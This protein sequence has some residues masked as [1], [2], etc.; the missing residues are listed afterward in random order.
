LFSCSVILVNYFTKLSFLFS[1]P[2]YILPYPSFCYL[3][4]AV[5]SALGGLVGYRIDLRRDNA[6]LFHQFKKAPLRWLFIRVGYVLIYGYWAIHPEWLTDMF[7]A[8][9]SPFGLSFLSVYISVPSFV[10]IGY[11]VGLIS[12]KAMSVRLRRKLDELLNVMPFTTRLAAS[13]LVFGILVS[14]IEYLDNFTEGGSHRQFSIY[15]LG[16]A[17]APAPV[18][19]ACYGIATAV[20]MGVIGRLI[21][22]ALLPH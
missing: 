10:S 7:I 15:M 1:L 20:L 22:K 21:D 19:W 3:Y 14:C 17:A 6:S 4:G 13:G 8:I 18:V 12:E 11:C 5:G 9:G 16:H 2:G